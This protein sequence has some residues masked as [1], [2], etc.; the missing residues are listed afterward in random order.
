MNPYQDLHL[1]IVPSDIS[2][3][4]YLE[5]W[6]K[7]AAKEGD[8]LLE[9]A[10]KVGSFRIN[11]NQINYSNDGTII[12]PIGL[13]DEAMDIITEND[14]LM[15]SEEIPIYIKDESLDWRKY[16]E[17]KEE[18]RIL[19]KQFNIPNKEEDSATYEILNI[20]KKTGT[21]T[22][23]TENTEIP[24]ENVSLSIYGNIKQIERREKARNLIRNAQSAN[25]ALGLL[26]EG[27]KPNEN[28]IKQT[29]SYNNPLTIFVRNKIFK[30]EPTEL[31][32]LQ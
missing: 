22:I 29:I 27:V 31:L 5:I 28:I 14:S 11:K 10:R 1:I 18:Q 12:Y 32:L 26:I 9:K 6:N 20:D 8:F 16:A 21:F 4:Y 2:R 15:F 17:Y 25:P 3:S 19:N 7:Y 24:Y 13:S 23:K 30:N